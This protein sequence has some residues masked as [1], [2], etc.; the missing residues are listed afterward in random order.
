MVSCS[1]RTKE[2]LIVIRDHLCVVPIVCTITCYYCYIRTCTDEDSIGPVHFRNS[3]STK[4]EKQV[5]GKN[6]SAPFNVKVRSSTQNIEI[7][8]AEIET[9]KSETIDRC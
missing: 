1:G 2:V 3:K 5:L 9:A 8:I 7:P 6:I 4:S